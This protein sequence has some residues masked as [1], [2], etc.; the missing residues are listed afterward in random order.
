MGS[1]FMAH[2]RSNLTIRIPR[3]AIAGLP[4]AIQELQ[5]SALFVKGRHDHADHLFGHFHLQITAAGLNVPGADS[6]AEL[7]KKIPDI[8]TFERFK[9]I[10]DTQI[11]ITIRGIGEMRP[12]NVN[13]RV[14]LSGELDE[15][16]MPRAFVTIQP[17]ADDTTLWDSMDTASDDVVLVFANGHPYEVL[18]G[19]SFVSVASGQRAQTVLPF[20]TLRRDGLGTTHHEA[21]TLAS[22]DNPAQSVTDSETKFHEVTNLYATGPAVFPTVGSPNPM[23]TGT[24][25]ARRLAD[26]LAQFT[27]AA[28]DAGFTMLFNG[29]SLSGWSMSTIVNQPGKG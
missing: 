24:A 3:G 8:D 14:A 11:V 20:A 10:T 18:V 22:G 15:F 28:P 21:G 5:A 7:F 12:G 1:N 25:L 16:Q 6:E 9:N 26:K 17:S 27:P 19:N 2:L 23:L 13:T 29:T 4:A